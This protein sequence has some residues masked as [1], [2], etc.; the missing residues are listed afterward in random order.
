MRAL[1]DGAP[2]GQETEP[3]IV[4]STFLVPAREDGYSWAPNW[5]WM[6]ASRRRWR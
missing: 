6:A 2:V 3:L 1:I 5:S 4:R